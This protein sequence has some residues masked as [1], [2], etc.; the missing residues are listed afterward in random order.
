MKSLFLFEKNRAKIM[1]IFYNILHRISSEKSDFSGIL[2][3]ALEH[4]EKNCFSSELSVASLATLCKVSEVYFRKLFFGYAGVSPKQ[5]ILDIRIEK[6]KQLLSDGTLKIS[7][8][9]E[10][11]GFSNPYHFCRQFKAKTG[12]TPTE[13]MKQNKIYKI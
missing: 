13:F 10:K 1:S 5:Y 3:P 11:C 8:L 7:A 4:I 6:A 9:S 2:S 12:F